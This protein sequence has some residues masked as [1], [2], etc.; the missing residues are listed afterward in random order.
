[1]GQVNTGLMVGLVSMPL[2][3]STSSR[4]ARALGLA[5][6]LVR[7]PPL[8]AL[9]GAA[10][11]SVFLAV[12]ALAGVNFGEYMSFGEACLVLPAR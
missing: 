3:S 7:H 11:R 10:I 12:V 4:A 2:L 9:R 1:M 8:G 5:L 6:L